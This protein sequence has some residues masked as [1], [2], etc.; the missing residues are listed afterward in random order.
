MNNV[1]IYGADSGRF[2][3]TV[4]AQERFWRNVYG[5]MASARFHR[6]ESDLGLSSTASAAGMWIAM[7]DF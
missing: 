6:P 7:V 3:T 1:K 5:G 2:G 4:D